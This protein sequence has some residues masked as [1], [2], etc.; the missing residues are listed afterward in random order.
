MQW[1]IVRSKPIGRAHGF[2]IPAFIHNMQYHYAQLQVFGDGLIDCWGAVDLEIFQR[3]LMKGW[4]VTNAPVGATVSFHNL[5]WSTVKT[6]NWQCTAADLLKQVDAGIELLNPNRI[7]L[8]DMDGDETELIQGK[9]RRYKFGLPDGKPFRV[10]AG[11]TEVL[12]DSLPVFLRIGSEFQITRW[13]IYADGSSRVG[14]NGSLT[15]MKEVATR[16]DGGD[17]CTAA[18]EGARIRIDGLGWFESENSGWGVKAQERVREAHDMLEQ[19]NGEQSSIRKCVNSFRE[20]QSDP[21]SENRDRL[22][23]AYEAVPEHLRRYCGDMDSQD[24]PI[25]GILYGEKTEW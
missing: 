21:S 8:I 10:D 15:S 17:M 2:A 20:Y 19:L 25:R 1:E 6:F 7:G 13:F 11:G 14:V 22:R 24:R 12:G 5:G 18:P 16:F 9:A 23:R 3:K 4:I